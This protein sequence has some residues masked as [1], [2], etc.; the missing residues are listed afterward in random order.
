M[1]WQ[2]ERHVVLVE[3]TAN[4]YQLRVP[5]EQFCSALLWRPRDSP[6][7]SVAES[8]HKIRSMLSNL[9]WPAIGR[10]SHIGHAHGG[11]AYTNASSV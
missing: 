1:R 9:H 5:R 10:R 8:A 7:G 2:R 11:M 6:A 3:M 4:F